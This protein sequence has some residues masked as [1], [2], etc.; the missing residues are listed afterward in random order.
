M[1][2][3]PGYIKIDKGYLDSLLKQGMIDTSAYNMLNEG[4]TGHEEEED[5]WSRLGSKKKDKKSKKHKASM[6]WPDDSLPPEP[7]KDDSLPS[8]PAKDDSVPPEPVAANEV[9]AVEPNEAWD[10]VPAPP[11]KLLR[12]ECDDVQNAEVE[13]V[14]KAER[15]EFKQ[16]DAAGWAFTWCFRCKREDVLKFSGKALPEWMVTSLN[17]KGKKE[18]PIV[19]SVCCMRC[20]NKHRQTSVSVADEEKKLRQAFE[21]LR[22]DCDSIG[23]LAVRVAKARIG[24]DVSLIRWG[25]RAGSVDV[26]MLK[27]NL[28]PEDIVV[29]IDLEAYREGKEGAD[30]ELGGLAGGLF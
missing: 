9:S 2:A 28:S 21:T 3:V 23:E 18:E 26:E 13:T 4:R 30:L 16:V 7:A 19:L 22:I 1:N 15:K 8:E 10:V 29:S 27:K 20:N 5:P 24:R 14:R 17:F 25:G 6:L 12:N 11:G